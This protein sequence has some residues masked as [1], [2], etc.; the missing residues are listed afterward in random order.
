MVNCDGSGCDDKTWDL[1][2]IANFEQRWLVEA[3]EGRCGKGQERRFDALA[4]PRSARG[5]VGLPNKSQAHAD[6]DSVRAEA[7]ALLGRLGS[8]QLDSLLRAGY[9]Y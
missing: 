9:V 7:L 4:T 1:G 2:H 3:V 5:D 6:M 8:M